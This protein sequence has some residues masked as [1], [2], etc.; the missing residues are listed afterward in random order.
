[1]NKYPNNKESAFENFIIEA[2]LDY[3]QFGVLDK[4]DVERILHEFIEDCYIKEQKYLLVIT[5]KG[6]LIQPLVPKLLT[7]NSYVQDFRIAGYF[8]GQEGAYEVILKS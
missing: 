3:H 1:M 6:N 4:L 5:G 2:E 8:T 7:K